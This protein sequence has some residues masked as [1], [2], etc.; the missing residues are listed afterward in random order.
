MGRNSTNNDNSAVG[1]GFASVVSPNGFSTG[2]LVYRYPSG[3]G[4]MPNG[5]VST[6]NFA[7]TADVINYS[8]SNYSNNFITADPTCYGGLIDQCAAKLTNGN[9]VISYTG[10]ASG[11]RFC[12]CF[13]I[14]NENNVEVVALTVVAT[15]SADTS[16]NNSQCSVVALT[17]GGFAIVYVA[18]GGGGTGTLK[19]RVY[20]NSGNVVSAIFSETANTFSYNYTTLV[21]ESRPNGGFIFGYVNHPGGQFNYQMCNADGSRNGSLITDTRAIVNST[22]NAGWITSLSDNRFLIMYCDTSNNNLY[23]DLRSS[24]NTSV[25]SGAVAISSYGQGKS[26]TASKLSTDVIAVYYINNGTVYHVK[27]TPNSTWTTPALIYNAFVSSNSIS[28]YTVPGTDTNIVVSPN[29]SDASNSQTLVMRYMRI[30][31]SAG[32]LVSSVIVPAFPDFYLYKMSFVSITGYIRTFF[33]FGVMDLFS[34]QLACTGGT[35]FF[36]IDSTTYALRNGSFNSVTS[37]TV[38]SG[39]DL[40]NKSGST[41]TGASFYSSA[42]TTLTQTISSG[43]YFK[44]QTVVNMTASTRFAMAKLNNG[45]FYIVARQT[46]G[47]GDLQ[48]AEFDALGN[49]TTTTGVFGSVGDANANSVYTTVLM[50]GNIIVSAYNSIT[51]LYKL[52]LLSPTYTVLTTRDVTGYQFGDQ[53]GAVFPLYYNNRFV[54][55]VYNGGTGFAN[56]V[57]LNGSSLATITTTASTA[58][59]SS[60]AY[61]TGTPDGGFITYSTSINTHAGRVLRF[62]WQG[63]GT[64]DSY[65][66]DTGVRNVT[67]ISVGLNQY[68]TVMGINQPTGYLFMPVQSG[69]NLAYVT[70]NVGQAGNTIIR[71]F[72]PS[73]TAVGAARNQALGFNGFGSP[74]YY[75]AATNTLYR[76]QPSDTT[77]QTILASAI[78]SI[79]SNET[80]RQTSLLGL[81]GGLVVIGI[82]NAS[83]KPTI[84]IINTIGFSYNVPLVANTTPSNPV[85]IDTSNGFSLIGVAASDCAAGGAGQ[86]QTKGTAVLSSS[87]PTTTQTFDFTNPVTYGVKGTV[88]NRVITLED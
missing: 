39:V 62:N 6:A 48:I 18:N 49:Q 46:I 63:T 36:D 55:C 33:R 69:S 88:S 9:I 73:I 71:S 72:S 29:G 54:L 35:G 30:N 85:T 77:T 32:T 74:V 42:T 41:P 28:S 27:F 65:V 64:P 1:A 14:V 70:G 16:T 19:W 10:I 75:N 44:T 86:V 13:R 76:L 4:V 31:G 24:T 78:P 50:N 47:A 15:I 25:S 37:G 12:P 83:D 80:N 59:S 43:A 22:Q 2:D 87:Y 40:Y 66:I 45:G 60:M 11:S 52:W 67:A 38:T 79:T 5:A 51:S 82:C 58:T 68:P 53:G 56:F 61:G 8:P 7:A 84:T 26:V 3:Y 21:V 57:V 81:A 17:G 23:W 34:S 20:D